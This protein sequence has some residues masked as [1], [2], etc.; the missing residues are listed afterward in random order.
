MRDLMPWSEANRISAPD[1]RSQTPQTA[2]AAGM[3][4]SH[5]IGRVKGATEERPPAWPHACNHPTSRAAREIQPIGVLGGGGGV[6]AIRWIVAHAQTLSTR[7]LSVMIRRADHTQGAPCRKMNRIAVP[8]EN[9]RCSPCL[10]TH[11]FL[12]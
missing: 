1:T 3:L 10:A 7:D 2:W 9:V 6:V 11:P 5:I 4:I 12:A 8:R